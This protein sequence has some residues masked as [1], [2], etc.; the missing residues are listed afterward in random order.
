MALSS[1]QTFDSIPRRLSPWGRSLPALLLTPLLLVPLAGRAGPPF[2]TD[3]PEPAEYQT[4]EVNYALAGTRSSWGTQAFAPGA[5]INYGAAPGVQLHAQLQM[6]YANADGDNG[7]PHYGLGDTELGLKYRLT[8]QPA[9]GDDDAWMVSVYPAVELPTG[10]ARRDLGA[11][12]SSVFLPVWVQKGWGQWTFDGGAGYHLNHADGSHNYWSG[13]TLVLYQFT[14]E[15]Q[16]GGEVFGSGAAALGERGSTGFSF[17]GTYKL[18][19]EASLL[20]SA[21]RGLSHVSNTNRASAYL[22]V[23]VLY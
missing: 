7:G 12:H 17:G 9:D 21:G 13:G 5:D 18:D 10:S 15:L 16:L 14:P 1:L 19:K 6:A 3:D 4:W 20:F 8:P 2:V 11:G 23:Q 22:G